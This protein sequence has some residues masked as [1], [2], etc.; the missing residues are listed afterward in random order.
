MQTLVIELTNE[1]AYKLLQDM[2]EL[3]LIRVVKNSSKLS[4]LR[5]RIR[6]RMTS[7]EIDNQLSVIR[8]EWQRNT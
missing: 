2:E 8:E 7:E 1:K 6:T 3:E 4:T 5:N